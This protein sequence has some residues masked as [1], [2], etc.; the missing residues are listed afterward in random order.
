MKIWTTL[1][2]VSDVE[3]HLS[4][5]A[6]VTKIVDFLAGCGAEGEVTAENWQKVLAG[7]NKEM[8]DAGEAGYNAVMKEHA[9][10][11]P[12]LVVEVSGDAVHQL[13]TDSPLL[14][15][16]DAAVVTSGLDVHDDELLTIQVGPGAPGE[17]TGSLMSVQKAAGWDVGSAYDAIENRALGRGMG[18]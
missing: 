15:G 5:G 12:R 17:F 16:L 6:A 4:R 10:P 8:E 7:L 11:D 2:G 18:R 1:T 13:H 9:L 3:V 14:A